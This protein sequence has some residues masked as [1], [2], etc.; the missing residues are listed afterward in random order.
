MQ[1]SLTTIRP[2]E[3]IH[4]ATLI[5]VVKRGK[6]SRYPVE[7]S[8]ELDRELAIRRLAELRKVN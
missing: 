4:T 7:L 6:Y 2:F 3:K 8:R 5:T 1:S